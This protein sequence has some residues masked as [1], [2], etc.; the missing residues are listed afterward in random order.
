MVIDKRSFYDIN[1]GGVQRKTSNRRANQD[2]ERPATSLNDP[3]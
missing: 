3:K 2:R 1:R